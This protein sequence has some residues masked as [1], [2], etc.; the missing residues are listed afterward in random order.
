MQGVIEILG[1]PGA[2]KS[3]AERSISLAGIVPTVSEWSG[4]SR[5]GWVP[6]SV[7]LFISSPIFSMTAYAMVLTRSGVRGI[8]VRRILSVQRRH[9]ILKLRPRG[10]QVLDEGPLHALFVAM[11]GTQETVLSR[12][13][14]SRVVRQL[15]RRV[16]HYVYIDESKEQCIAN[17]RRPGRTSARFN[18]DS[19]AKA[20]EEFRHDRTYDQILESVERVSPWKLVVVSSSAEVGVRIGR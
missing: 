16:D 11:Y 7:Q 19:S 15:A 12:W 14:L 2:G 20:V 10:T 5:W 13:L 17:F 3:S 6:M 4:P 18:A 8:T 1:L 9:L